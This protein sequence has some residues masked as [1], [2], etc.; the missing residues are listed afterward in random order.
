M[1]RKVLKSS[2]SK[3]FKSQLTKKNDLAKE[4][5]EENKED[6]SGTTSSLGPKVKKLKKATKKLAKNPTDAIT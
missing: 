5:N 2:Q 4:V 1:L 3:T 6:V